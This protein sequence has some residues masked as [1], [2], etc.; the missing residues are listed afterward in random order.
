EELQT[1]PGTPVALV[2]NGACGNLNPPGE[3][4][5]WERV[6]ELGMSVAREVKG[7]L[8]AA[9]PADEGVRC[10]SE[11]VRV[12]LE[13]LDAAGMERAAAAEVAKVSPA[14]PWYEPIRQATEAWKAADK[15]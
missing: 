14:H 5:S 7:M 10:T 6:R 9:S 3:G 1:L 2:T 11:R 15:A 12:P 4:W 8:A 13:V